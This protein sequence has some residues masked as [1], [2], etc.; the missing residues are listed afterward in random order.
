MW[1][2]D[3]T[4]ISMVREKPGQW[5]KNSMGYMVRELR[6]FLTDLKVVT[7]NS[8]FT[9]VVAVLYPCLHET[10]NRTVDL[11]EHT[12]KS[13]TSSTTFRAFQDQ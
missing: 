6:V 9:A 10:R 7:H 4:C 5:G 3:M 2:V 11:E 1:E 8:D 13:C 12:K